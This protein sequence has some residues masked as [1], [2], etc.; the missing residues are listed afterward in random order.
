MDKPKAS[1]T[2]QSVEFEIGDGW[3]FFVP[4]LDRWFDDYKSMTE[5]IDRAGKTVAAAKRR[6][7]SISA[8]T[9]DGKK[10]EVTGVHSG[11]GSLITKPK[12]E[13]FGSGDLYADTPLVKEAFSE[14]RRLQSD[15]RRVCTLL[16]SFR[17]NRERNY[18]EFDPTQH[19]AEIKRIEKVS[20]EAESAARTPLAAALKKVKIKKDDDE[21]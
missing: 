1:G 19:D 3:R 18:R 5:A 9:E 2:Y 14:K 4:D 7:V 10:F 21:Y 11:H 16:R 8:V 15:L 20:A 17:M 13:R 12:I 6:K